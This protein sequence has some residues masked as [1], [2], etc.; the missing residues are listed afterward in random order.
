MTLMTDCPDIQ[1]VS[2]VADPQPGNPLA[3]RAV[4]WTHA[5]PDAKDPKEQERGLAVAAAAERFLKTT[6]P[7]CTGITY[8]RV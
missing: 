7:V 4:V 1:N 6:S 2:I 3:Y 5:D 8:R